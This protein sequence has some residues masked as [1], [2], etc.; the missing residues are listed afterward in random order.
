[1]IPI[2]YELERLTKTCYDM[3]EL[4]IDQLKRCEKIVLEKNT[5]FADDVVRKEIR[6]NAFEINI[7]RQCEDILALK[8]PVATDLR[9]VIAI[10]KIS[11][12]LERIGDH[13]FHIAEY[14]LK[15]EL[16]LSDERYRELMLDEMFQVVIDMLNTAVNALEK[17]DSELA[18]SVSKKDKILDKNTKKAPVLLEKYIIEDKKVILAAL[19]TYRLISKIER[20]GDLIK[21]ITE[22]IIFYI[23]SEVVRHKKRNKKIFKKYIKEK[24]ENENEN[25]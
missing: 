5:E 1:M 16:Q 23:E 6:V 14:A 7:D 21:N 15:G 8:A 24:E 22:E 9:F 20:V 2:E 10:L 25:N 12:S 11:S 3:F 13:A 19:D 17:G 4:V 18:K